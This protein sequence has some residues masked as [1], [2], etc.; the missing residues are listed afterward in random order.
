M[1]EERK[2]WEYMFVT[3]AEDVPPATND[4]NKYGAEGWELVTVHLRQTDA[5]GGGG[6]SLLDYVFKRL[7]DGD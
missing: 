3:T 5:L 4:F 6:R 1:T 2:R 7:S